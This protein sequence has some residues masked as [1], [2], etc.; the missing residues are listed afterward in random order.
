MSEV[1][2]EQPTES[3]PAPEPAV[4]SPEPTPSPEPAPAEV[5]LDD[6]LAEFSNNTTPAP[7]PAQPSELDNLLAELQQSNEQ[8]QLNEKLGEVGRENAALRQQME[9]EK[10]N[11]EYTEF[12]DSIQKELPSWLPPDFADTQLTMA[13]IKNPDLVF[14]FKN[15]DCD[16][17]KV[18]QELLK[19]ETA[20][21]SAQRN[22]ILAQQLG[23][24]HIRQLFAYGHQLGLMLNS[25]AMIDRAKRDVLKR[26]DSVPRP[27]D[28]AQ[29]IH[30]VVAAA[31]RG[32][33]GKMD[34]KEP[35]PQWGNLSTNEYRAEIRK[36][37][38][39]DPLT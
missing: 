4:Q 27:P 26:G 32:A 37:Y 28:E 8:Q 15:R 34:A 5:P 6:L 33:G 7:E 25:R 3:A 31:V 18:H 2:E 21:A 22:P 16:R 17:Q 1:T 9:Q 19:V 24:Q 20:L 11:K 10:F 39:Y 12:S 38:G 36:R 35:A 29:E 30:D 13:A 14:A 23:E